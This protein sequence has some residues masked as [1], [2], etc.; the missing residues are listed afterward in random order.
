MIRLR[1]A[2]TFARHI[3]VPLT[4]QFTFASRFWFSVA[5]KT[6]RKRGFAN[7][8]VR[9]QFVRADTHAASHADPPLGIDHLDGADANDDRSRA[10]VVNE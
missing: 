9:D 2:L 1:E 5:R 10:T 6:R 3:L 4:G 7:R 8:R